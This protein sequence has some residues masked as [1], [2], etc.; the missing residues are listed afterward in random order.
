MVFCVL[1]VCFVECGLLQRTWS[2]C[3]VLSFCAQL[4]IFSLG[5][6]SCDI[7]QT[8]GKEKKRYGERARRDDTPNLW[9]AMGPL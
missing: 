6:A 8:G 4:L 5:R 9:M 7:G 3:L 1:F 2:Q